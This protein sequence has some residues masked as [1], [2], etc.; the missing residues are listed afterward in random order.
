MKIKI[1]LI[2][3]ML[4]VAIASI[5]GLIEY[6]LTGLGVALVTSLIMSIFSLLGLIPG[7]GLI[8]YFFLGQ[9]FIN[10]F[11][12]IAGLPWGITF[13]FIFIVFGFFTVLFTIFSLIMLYIFLSNR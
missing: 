11:T 13:N 10:L 2:W 3:S 5:M 9:S 12:G 8:V 7:I 4:F 1:D 6:G